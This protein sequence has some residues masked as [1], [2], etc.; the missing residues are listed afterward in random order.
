MPVRP[1]RFNG[2]MAPYVRATCL[3]LALGCGESSGM[4]TLDAG[5]GDLSMGSF[6]DAAGDRERTDAGVGDAGANDSAVA[7]PDCEGVTAAQGW[8][9][10]ESSVSACVVVFEDGTGCAGVCAALGLACSEAYDNVDGMCAAQDGPALGCGDTGH[11]SD[12]CVC[13]VAPVDAGVPADMGTAEGGA[14]D[15]G[16]VCGGGPV[17]HVYLVGDST[18]ASGSGWGDAFEAYLDGV[19]VTNTA[20]GGRSSKSFYDEGAFDATRDA[21]EAGDYVFI[22]FGH[23]DSKPEA[24]RRTEPGDAPNFAGTYREYL[25]RYIEETRAR[26]ATPILLT[27]VSRMT[28]SGGEHRRTHGNYAP[29]ARQ[30]ALDN[31][32]VLLD[33]EELSH[34]IFSELGDAETMRLYAEAPDRT[35]FPPDK[36]FR[37]AEMVVNLL[38]ES[39]SPLSCYVGEDR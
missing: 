8:D 29:A 1:A 24:Y 13:G 12:Y 20:R 28:F 15:A 32:V 30:A 35:H 25:E 22:Q 16:P 4:G 39:S 33:L 9:L 21:L 36:A 11:Q 23:N 38:A 37:V 17:P 7:A 3:L 27:P 31:G 26:G 10:C 14:L 19:S 18:T 6:A 5:L 34:Q 2:F